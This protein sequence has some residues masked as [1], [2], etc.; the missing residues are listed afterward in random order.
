MKS[1]TE[2]LCIKVKSLFEEGVLGQWALITW[3]HGGFYLM[4]VESK[5]D[6]FGVFL[7]VLQDKI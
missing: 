5:C 6:V 7:L 3:K 4:L 2:V 1:K